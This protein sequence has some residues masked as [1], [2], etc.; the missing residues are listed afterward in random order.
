[1]E[2]EQRWL[3]GILE[4]GGAVDASEMSRFMRAWGQDSAE[5]EQRVCCIGSLECECGSRK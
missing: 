3:D 4:N 1:M 2:T 5:D